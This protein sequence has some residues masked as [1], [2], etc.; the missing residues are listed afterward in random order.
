MSLEHKMPSERKGIVIQLETSNNGEVSVPL[1]HGYFHMGLCKTRPYLHELVRS[2]S[3][4]IL[5]SWS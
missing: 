5:K 3:A 4:N 1:E 2:K